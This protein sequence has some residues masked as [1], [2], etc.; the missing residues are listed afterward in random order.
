MPD[1]LEQLKTDAAE[2]RERGM[3]PDRVVLRAI[4]LGYGTR[5]ELRE[6]T[7]FD[8]AAIEKALERES[9][10]I[11]FTTKGS[12]ERISLADGNGNEVPKAIPFNRPMSEKKAPTPNASGG[13]VI[14]DS[15]KESELKCESCG[16]PRSPGSG[17][18]CRSCYRGA[19]DEK[20]KAGGRSRV[21][22]N[23]DYALITS[24]IAE[25]KTLKEIAK[26]YGMSYWTFYD[27]RF[28]D[29]QLKAAFAEGKAKKRQRSA[30]R[31]PKEDVSPVG[32]I[33]E[34]SE[35][36]TGA[37]SAGL[38]EP[39]APVIKISAVNS[40]T[41]E[42]VKNP[43]AELVMDERAPI[44][45]RPEI[46]ERIAGMLY[47]QD[48]NSPVL[49]DA[50]VEAEKA[51]TAHVLAQQKPYGSA[52]ELLARF[53]TLPSALLKE[54]RDDDAFFANAYDTLIGILDNRMA[55]DEKAAVWTLILYLKQIESERY[56]KENSG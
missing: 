46:R 41:G 12:I 14:A 53:N 40:K 3:A 51:I 32:Y 13:Y 52:E 19:A 37:V 5:R 42:T 24:M 45:T 43:K 10:A 11:R 35:P 48:I 29:P 23:F 34:K 1:T 30:R 20:K 4:G 50:L 56:A 18:L 38:S 49:T 31:T 7:G 15:R 33:E 44:L 28:Q 16:K 25:G 9:G 47:I 2:I 21:Q 17:R 26:F 54:I 6:V 39:S 36:S 22:V 27:R 8:Y 55:D